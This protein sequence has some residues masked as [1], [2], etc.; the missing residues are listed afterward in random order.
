[1]SIQNDALQAATTL[2]AQ[3]LRQ[4]CNV[5]LAC[6]IA[7]KKY[8]VP[9]WQIR[10]EVQ[11]RSAVKKRSNSSKESNVIISKSKTTEKNKTGSSS[12]NKQIQMTFDDIDF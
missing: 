6:N 2:A 11:K 9:T 5:I 8:G 10:Q 7:A 3:K 1:M 4:G 12:V